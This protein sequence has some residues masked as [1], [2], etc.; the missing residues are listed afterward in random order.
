MKT[1]KYIIPLLF[2]CMVAACTNDADGVPF[3]DIDG[4][5]DETLEHNWV[6]DASVSDEFD[7]L[8]ESKWSKS[9]WYS[10]TSNNAFHPDNVTVS[11]GILRITAKK[12]QYNGKEYTCGAL[13]SNFRLGVNTCIEIRAKTIDHRANVTTALWLSNQPLVADNPNVEIDIMET[14]SAGTR[15]KRFTGTIHYWE[16]GTDTALE[17]VNIDVP[18]NSI[19]DDFHVYKLIRLENYVKLYIDDIPFWKFN[20]TDFYNVSH[21]ERSVVFSVEGHSGLPVE[22]FLPND[23]LIDYVRVYRTQ[24][25]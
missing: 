19:S 25:M 9:L 17:W 20:T 1:I 2:A 15:P 23:F 8:D 3:G 6:L 24:G 12:E 7:N 21:Q 11:D 14:L 22:E 13:I 10:V 16:N 4:Y 5:V 18:S